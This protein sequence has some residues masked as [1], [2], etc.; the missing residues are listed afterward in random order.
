MS[1]SDIQAICS[2]L[3]TPDDL[4]VDDKLFEQ[5]L[6]EKIVT[7]IL[8]NK[9]IKY[10]KIFSK[11]QLFLSHI[12]P[13]LHNIG[14]EIIDE[15]TY[16]VANNKELIYIS[17]F[18]LNIENFEQIEKAKQNLETIISYSLKDFTVKHSKAFSLVYT[19]N[20][21]LR[22]VSL[23]R[24]FIEYID[25]AVLTINSATILNT[26]TQNHKLASMFVKYFITKFE[27]NID[28]RV[29]KLEEVE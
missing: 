23:I 2:Q 11:E 14:F 7:K 1:T 27:P 15:V 6:K 8:E 19:Q 28:D 13:L 17:R 10:I 12:T 16:N 20:L 24:A 18:N 5:V 21:D 26:L 4:A 22:K 25:Q 3:L 9:K 29:T